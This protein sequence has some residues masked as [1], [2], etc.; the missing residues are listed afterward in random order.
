MEIY[1]FQSECSCS[2]RE[3]LD[4]SAYIT[5]AKD[6]RYKVE[7]QASIWKEESRVIANCIKLRYDSEIVAMKLEVSSLSSEVNTLRSHLATGSGSDEV[8]AL[9]CSTLERERE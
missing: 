7:Q 4:M 5:D 8:W 9:K 3:L 2:N 6:M 1:T